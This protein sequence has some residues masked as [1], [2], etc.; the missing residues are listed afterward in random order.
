M[1]YTGKI[2]RDEYYFILL[3]GLLSVFAAQLN[4]VLDIAG[5]IRTD[6]REIVALAS[7]FYL[8]SWR[9]AVLVGLFAALGGPYDA[10]L[11]QNI[12]MHIIAIPAGWQL[13]YYIA[14]RSS[15][16]LLRPLLW[17]IG[18]L[19]LYAFVYSPVYILFKLMDYTISYHLSLKHYLDILYSI[20]LE[21]MA[22]AVV[23]ALILAIKE[24]RSELQEQQIIRDLA[25]HHGNIGT[26]KLDLAENTILMNSLWRELLKDEEHPGPEFP[27]RCFM[28]RLPDDDQKLLRQHL[29]KTIQDQQGSFTVQLT[30]ATRENEHRT[31]IMSGVRLPDSLI[32][33]GAR[34]FGIIVDI[35]ELI[36]SRAGEEKLRQQLLQSQKLEAI[37]TLAGG[38]A[39]DFNNILTVILGHSEMMLSKIDKDSEFSK[40]LSVILSSSRRAADLTNQILAFSRKQI[41]DPKIIAL[42]KVVAQYETFT[43]RLIGED[44]EVEVV[45]DE[46]VKT[47]KADPV[48]IEQVLLNL[49][50]N[51]RDALLQKE[52]KGFR[53]KITIETLCV[54][55][56]E[57]ADKE[58]V[59]GSGSF[60]VL[61][62]SDNGSGMDA[63]T[64]EKIFEP[65]FTTKEK[66]K[67][68]GLGLSTVYGIVKQNGGTI[69]VYSEPDVGTTFK[70]YWPSTGDATGET[71][72]PAISIDLLTG[73]ENI[74]LVEDEK[75]VREFATMALSSL[76]YQVWPV[77]DGREAETF[78]QQGRVIPDILVTDII[79]PFKSGKEVAEMVKEKY[80]RCIIL[81]TSGYTD[82]HIVHQGELEPNINF[83]PKPYTLQQLAGFIR[84]LL[85]SRKDEG[86]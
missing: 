14:R 47:I 19:F 56:D 49:I 54:S 50:V 41:Y 1:G 59:P 51:A 6:P 20:R 70:I 60:T 26:W 30:I 4:F 38:I 79:L 42:N 61:S 18:V 22:T 76:G 40:N 52:A 64:R 27:F 33:S 57:T 75:T 65:F 7:V 34:L 84:R 2:K 72:E 10:T 53:K 43:R 35:S 63:A 69:T 21:I 48:Q 28:D 16:V 8:S 46:N 9:S 86:K 11:P 74:L 77:A 82:N 83:L 73:N 15:G 71:I 55:L 85:K 29:D 68:T 78:I 80:P 39:H 5:G 62:V 44:I 67:G 32:S 12:A 23:T 17:G 37:G 81:Y 36:K 45:L 58:V 13:Y 66:G 3:F 31:I 25:L 24:G